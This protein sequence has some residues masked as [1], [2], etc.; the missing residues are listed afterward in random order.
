MKPSSLDS[1]EERNRF[2]WSHGRSLADW[3]L[4]QAQGWLSR[5]TYC[6]PPNRFSKL[7]AGTVGTAPPRRLVVR[8]PAPGSA[9]ASCCRGEGCG[10]VVAPFLLSVVRCGLGFSLG[11]GGALQLL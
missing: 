10:L 2:G 9:L 3:S 11:A 8:P 6:E 4:L 1:G 7:P 5:L